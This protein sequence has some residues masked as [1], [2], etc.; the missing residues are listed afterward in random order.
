[1]KRKLLTAF[2]ALT[3]VVFSILAPFN[4]ANASKQ[5]DNT[6]VEFIDYGS[7]RETEE[8]SDVY[9][10]SNSKDNDGSEKDKQL[11]NNEHPENKELLVEG[12]S[13][14]SKDENLPLSDEAEEFKKITFH[15]KDLDY[16]NKYSQPDHVLIKVE[17]ILNGEKITYDDVLDIGHN[18]SVTIE[19]PAKAS[20]VNYQ[21]IPK[22][23]FN[24]VKVTPEKL[25]GSLESHYIDGN[26]NITVE[27]LVERDSL[28]YYS[29]LETIS[30]NYLESI[31]GGTIFD[32][33]HIFRTF[34]TYNNLYY[35]NADVIKKYIPKGF[36]F[37]G[38]S[39]T[40]DGSNMVNYPDG[41]QLA[42][43]KE[44]KL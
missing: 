7:L 1:M 28:R 17:Y 27:I 5:E 40:Q 12:E 24:V 34:R 3:I 39:S 6:D 15:N 37:K 33:T 30:F 29:N 22:G 18:Q 38:W 31:E 16:T 32:L 20:D 26:D 13:I 10:E 25:E 2:M 8:G 9:K 19:L 11:D 23:D 35:N 41:T 14:E 44:D 36:I 42:D 43:I 4:L 21:V